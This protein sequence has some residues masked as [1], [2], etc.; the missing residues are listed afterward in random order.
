MRDQA[1][2]LIAAGED[3]RLFGRTGLLKYRWRTGLPVR[4]ASPARLA[5]FARSSTDVL[6]DHGMDVADAHVVFVHNLMAEAVRYLSRPE[7]HARA[8]D[9][10][11]FFRSLRATAPIIA[12]SRMVE[13][14]LIEHFDLR[15]DRISVIYP[16]IDRSRFAAADCEAAKEEA[17]RALGIATGIPLVGFVTSGDFEKRGLD[18]FLDAAQRIAAARPDVHFL[19]A[20]SRRLPDDAGAHPLVAGKRLIHRPKSAKPEISFAALDLFLYPARFEE[21][22]MVVA[23]A[24]AAGLPVLTSRRVGAAE[25]LPPEYDPWLLDEPDAEEFAEKALALLDDDAARS[26]LAAAGAANASRFDRAAYV[27]VSIRAIRGA[28]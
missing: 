13:R 19:V 7:W 9:E 24:Q 11:R 5:R 18:V 22:G 14:A 8:E 21:F 20:G 3:V 1:E 10:R 27:E 2:G 12:N 23:E 25:C 28:R 4:R 6:V 26:R 16:G 17:R 15:P